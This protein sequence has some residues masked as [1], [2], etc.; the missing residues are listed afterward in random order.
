MCTFKTWKIFE[1]PGKKFKKIS[2]NPVLF[3]KKLKLTSLDKCKNNQ[4]L[5]QTN[6]L[7]LLLIFFLTFY[8]LKTL[9]LIKPFFKIRFTYIKKII[10]LV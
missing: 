2:G 8:V 7:T 1:K 10:S 4:L 5:K 3:L 6:L 9:S